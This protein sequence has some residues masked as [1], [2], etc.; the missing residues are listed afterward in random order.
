MR[1]DLGHLTKQGDSKVML[2][3]PPFTG[4]SKVLRKTT[5]YKWFAPK[6]TNAKTPSIQSLFFILT[7]G[8]SNGRIMFYQQ[9]QR[10]LLIKSL[11]QRL[12]Q[13]NIQSVSQRPVSWQWEQENGRK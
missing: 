8:K 11:L 12:I 4:S 3:V 2:I 5:V 10:P 7:M 13:E 1:L 9:I 6:K